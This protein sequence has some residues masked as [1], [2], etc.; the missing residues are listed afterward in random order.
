MKIFEAIRWW[1]WPLWLMVGGQGILIYGIWKFATTIGVRGAEAKQEMIPWLL[2]GLALYLGGRA[3]QM[4]ARSRRRRLDQEERS[5][6][7]A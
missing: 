5:R 2:T 7:D 3:L 1:T 6:E 4:A